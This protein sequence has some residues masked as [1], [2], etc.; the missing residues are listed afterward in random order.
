MKLNRRAFTLVEIMIVIMII[1][2]LI[3][4]AMPALLRARV[5]ANDGSI[6]SDMRAFSSA[7]E[8][9][10]A[11]QIPPGYPAAIEDLTSANPPYLDASWNSP[12]TKHGHTMTYTSSEGNFTLT[13]VSQTGQ[14]VTDYCIDHSG[15]LKLTSATSSTT[16]TG[17]AIS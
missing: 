16:C 7:A 5:N 6:R 17:T 2:V 3:A 9:Y 10:R 4:V 12:S 15:V 14:S 11:A 8:G 1:S 13:A